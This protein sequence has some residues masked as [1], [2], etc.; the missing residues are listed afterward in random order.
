ME[1][2]SGAFNSTPSP[3]S[4]DK[5]RVFDVK[6]LRTLTPVFPSNPQGPPFVCSPPFGPYPPGFAPFY[7]FSPQQGGGPDPSPPPQPPAVPLR[8]FRAPEPS[9]HENGTG[10]GSYSEP[11]KRAGRR[12]AVRTIPIAKRAKRGP[13]DFLL[14][15]PNDSVVLGITQ[16]QKED[17]DRGTV[18]SILMRFDALRRKVGQLEDVKDSQH[19]GNA[20][21]ADLKASA[22]L[23]SNSIR[24]N[25][26]KRT[27]HVP[28]VEIGDIF[29]FRMEMC[30]VG[31]HAQSMAGIDY[32]IVRGDR[33]EEPLATSI[34]SSG[35]YDNAADDTDILIYSGHGGSSNKNKEASDQKLVRGNLA[36]ER[37][38]QKGNEV[39]VIRGLKD[40]NSPTTKIYVYDGLYTI[41]ES[42]VE[43]AKT[44]CNIFKYK[45]VRMSGQPGAFSVW[46]SVA[47]WKES[48]SS[49]VGLILHDLTLAAET[50]PVALVNDVDGERG[51]TCFTYLA[52]VRYS[53]SFKLS[54]QTSFGCNCRNAC[55][56]GD[57]NCA[58]MTK[59][60]GQTPYIGNGV[61]V[62]RKP[63]VYECG[64]TCPCTAN[65]K[66]RVSQTGLKVHLEV[67]KTKDRGWGLRS[68]DPIRAGTFICIYAGEA[69]NKAI[70]GEVGDSGDYV[71]DTTRVYDSFRWNCEPGFIEE[72]LI[73]TNEEYDMPYPLVISAKN[74][75][76][77]ARFMNHSCEPNTFWQPVV[78]ENNS[79]TYLNVAFFAMRHIPPMTELTYDYGTPRADV[80]GGSNGHGRMRCLCGSTRCKGYFV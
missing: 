66:N 57:E 38:L 1:G 64:P 17:G 7:P 46:K 62:C 28:G 71:F 44:G 74:V 45:I 59:N 42:W 61:L 16:A 69:T 23:M 25:T 34:V 31:L 39:R 15:A 11:P 27:G 3:G 2:G 35:Y 13:D 29:F 70:S 68:W 8:S 78:Y 19:N 37:S 80:P 32:L 77:V 26:K 75:G 14:P 72:D 52:S 10:G 47:Q 49:R 41:Q 18:L 50:I 58:C 79:E 20:K 56:S 60:G 43:K 55:Q 51:P 4:F 5:S 9:S 30:L 21:R 22:I 24:T 12:P 40:A 73:D 54:H 48:V 65:C 67:F 6:P 76:N 53:K 36:L 63:L 33:E